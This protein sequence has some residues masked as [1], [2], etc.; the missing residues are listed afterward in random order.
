[1]DFL[2]SLTT[3]QKHKSVTMRRKINTHYD[4]FITL[5]ID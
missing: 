2:D 1:M 3:T 5:L 4:L